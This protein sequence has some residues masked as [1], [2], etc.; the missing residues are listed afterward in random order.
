MES[1][2][3]LVWHLDSQR[4]RQSRGEI[5]LK[6]V[7]KDTLWLRALNAPEGNLRSF[8]R[9]HIRQFIVA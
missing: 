7:R 4:E 9:I 5:H 6:G 1:L 8:S 3:A 2:L